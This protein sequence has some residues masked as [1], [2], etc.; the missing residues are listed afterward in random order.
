MNTK[1]KY[2][3]VMKRVDKVKAIVTAI[4]EDELKDMFPTYKNILLLR[5]MGIAEHEIKATIDELAIEAGAPV[6]DE[7]VVWESEHSRNHRLLEDAL[8]ANP[9]QL[10]E[11]A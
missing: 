7:D 11:F 1:L 2:D 4:S 8:K 5:E 3:D 9:V 10:G 6:D